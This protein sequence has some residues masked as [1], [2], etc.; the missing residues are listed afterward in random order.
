MPTPERFTGEAARLL[1]N[2]R[3]RFLNQA[4]NGEIHPSVAERDM[5]C[6]AEQNGRTRKGKPTKS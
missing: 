4:R 5:H 6:D 1:G 2:K 3:A